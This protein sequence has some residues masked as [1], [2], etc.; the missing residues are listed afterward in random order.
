MAL[1]D[2]HKSIQHSPNPTS[3]TEEWGGE[4]DEGLIDEVPDR[5]EN[6]YI[7]VGSQLCRAQQSCCFCPQNMEIV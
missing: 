7:P 5:C 6:L 1:P 3:T 2:C 4:D